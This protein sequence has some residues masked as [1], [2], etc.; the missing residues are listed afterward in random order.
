MQEKGRVLLAYPLER[1]LPAIH[2]ARSMFSDM[3]IGNLHNPNDFSLLPLLAHHPRGANECK[4]TY[5]VSA[6]VTSPDGQFAPE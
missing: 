1:R 5:G 3:G 6:N 4:F 2:K